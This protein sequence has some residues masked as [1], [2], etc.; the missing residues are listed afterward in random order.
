MPC[1]DFQ[2]PGLVAE[3]PPKLARGPAGRRDFGPRMGG[4]LSTLLEY[5]QYPDYPSSVSTLFLNILMKQ[6]HVTSLSLV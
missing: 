4:T 5:S 1:A 3:L 6:P 2:L